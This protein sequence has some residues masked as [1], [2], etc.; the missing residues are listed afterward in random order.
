MNSPWKLLVKNFTYAGMGTYRGFPGGALVK[1]LP[2]SAEGSRDAGSIPGSGR[3]SGERNGNPLHYFC[4]E[5]SM[6]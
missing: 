1:N 4:L 6:D 5:N 3:F 2:A